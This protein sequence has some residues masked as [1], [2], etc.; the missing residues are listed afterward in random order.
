MPDLASE[1]FLGGPVLQTTGLQMSEI[2]LELELE[3]IQTHI[4][5][6]PVLRVSAGACRFAQQT[7]AMFETKRVQSVQ[8]L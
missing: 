7:S 1:N 8:K 4:T 2:E 3:L 6:K 5:Q